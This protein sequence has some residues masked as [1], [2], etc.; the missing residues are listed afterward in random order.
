MRPAHFRA[1]DELRKSSLIEDL[2]KRIQ[3]GDELNL[4]GWYGSA[5]PLLTDLLS[6]NLH[7]P[8]FLLL[9][10]E[11]DLERVSSELKIWTESLEIHPYPFVHANI[12]TLEHAALL[13]QM[14]GIRAMLES[15]VE[16]GLWVSTLGALEAPCFSLD[17]IDEPV[18]LFE[19][20][21]SWKLDELGE[22]LEKRGFNHQERVDQKGDYTIRGGILDIYPRFSS[23]PF[24]LDFF[25]D[26]LE[27][28]REF[29]SVTQRSLRKV[30]RFV[31][32]DMDYERV[33][34]IERHGSLMDYLPDNPVFL[35]QEPELVRQHHGQ[36]SSISGL[37]KLL[38]S[39]DSTER[40][41]RGIGRAFFSR[42]LE[43][44]AFRFDTKT[45]DPL[46]LSLDEAIE[47]LKKPS[48]L[49]TR[50]LI[51]SF[52]SSL[53]LAEKGQL[54]IWN[55]EGSLED[56]FSIP[57]LGVEV[58]HEKNLVQISEIQAEESGSD[59]MGDFVD[60]EMGD[61]IVHENYGVGQ[62]LGLTSMEKNG[63]MSDFL[64]LQFAGGSKVYVPVAQLNLVQ[65]YIGHGDG[66]PELSKIG[67]KSWEMKKKRARKAIDKIVMELV[68]RQAF[69]A[70]QPGFSYS[71]DTPEQRAFER[72]FPYN[73][74]PCQSSA[75]SEIKRAMEKVEPMD[76]LLCGDVGFGKTEV[77]MRIAHK[78]ALDEKQVAILAPTT[79]LAEQHYNNF[80]KRFQGK[81]EWLAVLD[82]FKTP[83][84]TREVL[85]KVAAGEVR[86]LIGTHR[87]LS[88]DL[89]FLDLGLLILD[90]EQRFGVKQKEALKKRFPN[91][92]VLSLSATPI[93]RTLH[94]SMLGIRT[95]SNLTVPPE[96]RQPIR[97]Y[98]RERQKGIIKHAIGRELE[99]GGQ[100][101]FLHNR[102][103]DIHQVKEELQSYFPQARIGVGHGQMN[104]KEL[105]EVMNAF[106]NLE[107][108]I[109]LSTSIVANGIDIPTANTMIV[110]DA[111]FFGLSE[112]HQIRGRIGRYS[113]QAYC[114][115]LVPGG[116]KLPQSSMRRLRA[117]E[118]HQDL[119][120]GFKLAMKDM[121]IR[122]V[123]N[124]LGEDQHGQIADIGYEL[125]TQYLSQAISE[126]K[127][128]SP[129]LLI[130][131]ELDWNL[132]SSYFPKTY[133]PSHTER[134]DFYRRISFARTS[135]RLDQIQAE[136]VDRYGA[137]PKPTKQLLAL[138]FAKTRLKEM[139]V[140]SFKKKDGGS[141]VLIETFNWDDDLKLKW[142][143]SNPKTLAFYGDSH[144][145]VKVDQIWDLCTDEKVK[146]D[147]YTAYSYYNDD[148]RIEPME[149]LEVVL[150]YMSKTQREAKRSLKEESGERD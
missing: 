62:F 4:S 133:M 114:Y 21:Q 137:P 118:E 66:Q 43:D 112:L 24:R 17:F 119:G 124:L 63:T 35:I 32:D 75:S 13:Q 49:E 125:Y 14:K 67:A 150:D 27:S 91:I 53:K 6:A 144:I 78:A 122:G 147:P 115:L 120:A 20:G 54:D 37:F 31:L 95:I 77:A 34:N 121:E 25:G 123:G 145:L 92:D 8:V 74:T 139:G 136:L 142:V 58:F 93:P 57:C 135:G 23:N 117:V 33:N 64:L 86:I 12:T 94:L 129:E 7:R 146:K 72:A 3:N 101:Y 79:V 51:E 109:F 36:S 15:N 48:S 84:Q 11:R 100:S 46:G 10:D 127:G 143:L 85:L 90:E 76:H 89:D 149:V 97:T 70:S 140:I 98:I 73:D 5:I 83:K 1:V 42:E 26:E 148:D 128:G 69:R 61:Y 28:I 110:N 60:L 111:H 38:M 88:K 87:L 68:R 96:N 130:E 141:T 59:P 65:K 105:S 40:T 29:S 126:M 16:K 50:F 102:I 131:T 108:D 55:L 47:H 22:T 116:A 134:I 82:R 44:S 80:L 18:L 99:R 81:K 56:N 45:E 30:Q 113:I 39:E 9:Q 52:G 19:P 138:F 2:Q 104:E 71:P 132:G 106:F 41:Q 103:E 107:I